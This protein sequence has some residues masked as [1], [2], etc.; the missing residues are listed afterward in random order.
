MGISEIN[1]KGINKLY[2]YSNLISSYSNKA[3]AMVALSNKYKGYSTNNA[4]KTFFISVVNI[5]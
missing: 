1:N 4:S 3:E 2:N 5:K